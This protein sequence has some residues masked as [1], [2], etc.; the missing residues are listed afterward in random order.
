MAPFDVD[1]RRLRDPRSRIVLTRRSRMSN[2]RPLIKVRESANDGGFSEFLNRRSYKAPHS[3]CSRFPNEAPHSTDSHAAPPTYMG[4]SLNPSRFP[5]W[6]V[7]KEDEP[8]VVGITQQAQVSRMSSALRPSNMRGPGSI[9]R[10][11][12]SPRR[13]N[14]NRQ[15]RHSTLDTRRR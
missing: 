10:S 9:S 2:H 3:R 13:R 14:Q 5:R 15:R 8:T 7:D 12:S 1:N 4:R 11:G 6:T